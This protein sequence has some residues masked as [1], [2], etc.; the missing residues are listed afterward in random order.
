MRKEEKLTVLS[1]MLQLA[2][3]DQR[4]DEREL[5]FIRVVAKRL[6][7]SSQE[8]REL[9]EKPSTGVPI[10][11]EAN[12]IV[13]FHRLV[14]LMNVD[15]IVSP[16]EKEHLYHLGLDMGLRKEA[17]DEVFEVMQNYEYGIVP[18]SVL[19]NVF[20]RFYN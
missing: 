8:V 13:Q 6:G 19:I 7:I 14:L 5:E 2:K 4:L 15:G 11:F 20:K 3:A 17:I 12:R 1:E 9:N 18:S 16:E 10:K